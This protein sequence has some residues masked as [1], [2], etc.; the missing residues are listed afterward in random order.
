MLVAPAIGEAKTCQTAGGKLR[1]SGRLMAE[2]GSS[3]SEIMAPVCAFSSP[4][5]TVARWLYRP[6][7]LDV[8]T[9]KDH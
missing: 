6:L 9:R 4:P 5:P 8:L 1:S 7:T 2:S 3:H